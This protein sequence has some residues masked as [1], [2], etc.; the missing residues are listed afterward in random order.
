[1]Q[2]NR[3]R[4]PSSHSIRCYSVIPW[5]PAARRALAKP[6]NGTSLRAEI[7]PFLK[8]III[9]QQHR[10]FLI[11]LKFLLR[12]RFLCPKLR[13]P[14]YSV[15]I[16]SNY[17]FQL[18]VV[19]SAPIVGLNPSERIKEM[20]EAVNVEVMEEE[21][22]HLVCDDSHRWPY[23]K[24][25]LVRSLGNVVDIRKLMHSLLCEITLSWF[26]LMPKF[27]SFDLLV[28]SCLFCP[29]SSLFVRLRHSRKHLHYLSRLWSLKGL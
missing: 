16:V 21:I 6:R 19:V 11:L 29:F 17:C 22:K 5:S 7:G 20:V 15:R 1:M 3:S 28:S 25:I 24:V 14:G 9:D 8:M 13:P 4:I 23:V 18:V 26:S 27:S 10:R 12:R 2:G